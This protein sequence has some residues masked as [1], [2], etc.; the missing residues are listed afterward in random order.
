MSIYLVPTH[1]NSF[2]SFEPARITNLAWKE[3][4]GVGRACFELE[5]ADGTRDSVPILDPAAGYKFYP[6][7]AIR[8]MYT[9][10]ESPQ[11]RMQFEET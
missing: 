9:L 11:K 10:L 3:V 5:Y 4:D 6:D 2:R 8:K 7:S 1:E